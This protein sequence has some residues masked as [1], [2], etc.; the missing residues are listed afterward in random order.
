MESKKRVILHSD[1]NNFFA[2]VETALN[3]D[4]KGK[5]V[6]VC[7]S[8]EER[9]GIVLA[10]SEEAKKYGIKTAMTIIEAKRLCPHLLT[11]QSHH[12][13][14]E[15][16]SLK[17]RKIYERFTDRIEPFGID[18]AWLDVTDSVKLFGSGEKIANTIRATVKILWKTVKS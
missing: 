11:V 3:P 7:G 14:Y 18:E 9:H 8:V 12:S 13:L 10:K 6:A 4:L 1:L 17:V 15:E 16:Y 2:S 5:A